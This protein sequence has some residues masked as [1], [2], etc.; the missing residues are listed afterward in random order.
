MASY[1][2]LVQAA[3]EGSA[4][5]D[6]ITAAVAIAAVAINTE[7]AGT[8]N[9]ANRMLWAKGALESPRAIMKAML[10]AVIASNK[11]ASY[12]AILNA[13]DAQVQANVDALVDMFAVG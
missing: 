6:R 8:E 11:A 9:H 7:D 5:Q 3:R 13:T 12:A 2:E 4:L 10:P 1:E